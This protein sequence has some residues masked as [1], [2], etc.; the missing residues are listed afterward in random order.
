V[1]VNPG[2]TNER[3][4]REQLQRAQLRVHADNRTIFAEIAAGR[5]DAMVT[6]DVEIM[7]QTRRDASLCRATPS[8]FTRSEKAILLPRDSAGCVAVAS[9]HP[10]AADPEG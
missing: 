9:F 2:G 6:D 4:A 10:R 5:A 3:Y 1:I 8:L 7:L